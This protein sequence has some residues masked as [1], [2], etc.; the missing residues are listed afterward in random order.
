MYRYD[1][2][3]ILNADPKVIVLVISW[4]FKKIISSYTSLYCNIRATSRQIS[5]GLISW[6]SASQCVTFS[7]HGFTFMILKT[8]L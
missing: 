3:N 8:Y 4:F 1:H 5:I 6:K 7:R 2:S